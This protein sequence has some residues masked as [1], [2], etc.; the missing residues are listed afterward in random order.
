M[1]NFKN[2]STEIIST[3]RTVPQN[4]TKTGTIA[5][6]G[7]QVVGTGT[8]FGTEVKVGDWICSLSASEI[9]KIVTITDALTAIIDYPFTV[10]LAPAT[11]L[12]VIPHPTN[13]VE[14]S[15]LNTGGASGSIDGI[16]VVQNEYGCWGK[17]SRERESNRDFIDPIIV[18]GTGTTIKILTLK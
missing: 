6:V 18:D 16:A 1:A 4:V 14:I 11:A 12:V 15:W 8:L 10:D 7:T 9:R 13:I 17:N 5:T 3:L 2:N